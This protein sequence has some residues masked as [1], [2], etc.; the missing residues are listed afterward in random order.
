[1]FLV[2]SAETNTFLDDWIDLMSFLSLF[3]KSLYTLLNCTF[4]I[5]FGSHLQIPL[6]PC[7]RVE[8]CVF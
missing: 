5:I 8:T 1:M 2:L 7:V 6:N 4:Q 3:S